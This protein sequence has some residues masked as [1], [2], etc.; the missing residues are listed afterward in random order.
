MCFNVPDL[1]RL[2]D[3]IDKGVYKLLSRRSNPAKDCS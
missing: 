1:L 3:R 2:G